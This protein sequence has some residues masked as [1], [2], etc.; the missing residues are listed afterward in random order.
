MHFM[1]AAIES[2]SGS[3]CSVCSGGSNERQHCIPTDTIP[4]IFAEFGRPM[5]VILVT[6]QGKPGGRTLIRQAGDGLPDGSRIT[7]IGTT[8]IVIDAGDKRRHV[9]LF[10]R[11]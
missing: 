4:G 10:S 6:E 8:A 11:N 9:K 3:F 2:M 7:E 1:R 5:A